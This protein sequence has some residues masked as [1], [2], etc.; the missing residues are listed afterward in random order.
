MSDAL[1]GFLWK[2]ILGLIVLAVIIGIFWVADVQTKEA[3]LR[4]GSIGSTGVLKVQNVNLYYIP[5]ISGL[6]IIMKDTVHANGKNAEVVPVIHLPAGTSETSW[7]PF[8]KD[9][10][11]LNDPGAYDRSHL[12]TYILPADVEGYYVGVIV[13]ESWLDN[14]IHISVWEEAC[15]RDLSAQALLST[16]DNNPVSFDILVKK[17]AGSYLASYYVTPIRG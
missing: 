2:L 15:V 5:E 11:G 4:A 3:Q 16:G 12:P 13:D 17:C 14:P 10:S 8:F 7:R 6:K 9:E 1:T